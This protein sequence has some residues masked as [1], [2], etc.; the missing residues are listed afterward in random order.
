MEYCAAAAWS[1][2]YAKDKHLLER[3][4]HRFTRMFPGLRRLPSERLLDV[5]RLW[6]LEERRNRADFIE[7]FKIVKGFSS[8][9]P[10]SLSLARTRERDVTH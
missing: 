7:V 1:L 3:I 8:I 9:C 6:S 5:L 10:Q 2:H 4:Q